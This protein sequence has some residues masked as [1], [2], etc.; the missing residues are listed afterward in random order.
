MVKCASKP[1]AL[2]H[3]YV[4]ADP[5]CSSVFFLKS[6][7]HWRLPGFSS[8]SLLLR[9]Q[10]RRVMRMM[11]RPMAV[12]NPST[13]GETETQK[14]KLKSLLSGIFYFNTQNHFGK[15]MRL[16]SR[17][18]AS[19]ANGIATE[20]VCHNENTLLIHST[21]SSDK[22]DVPLS[23]L[24]IK[25]S[26]FDILRKLFMHFSLRWELDKRLD[27]TLMSIN[28]SLLA[29]KQT[30]IFLPVQQETERQF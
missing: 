28:N 26:K 5:P 23:L 18:L 17:R 12:R 13:S 30:I 24:L 11:K 2:K 9:Y 19:N 10:K 25:A 3:R 6:S 21:A 20:C 1:W 29:M 4:N 8:A 14:L 22:E 15:Q 16:W 27:T 7:R